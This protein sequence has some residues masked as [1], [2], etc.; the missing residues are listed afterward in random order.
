MVQTRSQARVAFKNNEE[1]LTIAKHF[2]WIEETSKI[3]DELKTYGDFTL[4]DLWDPGMYACYNYI[5]NSI[6]LNRSHTVWEDNI[7]AFRFAAYH[8]LYH[9]LTRYEMYL[10]TFF[11]SFLY[12]LACY[13]FG[14]VYAWGF[15][16]CMMPFRIL[17]FHNWE[18]RCDLFSIA[19]NKT[20]KGGIE[21]IKIFT[22]A[23]K[24]QEGFTKRSFL[25]KYFVT[26]EGRNLLD[27]LHPSPK[28]RIRYMT[29][30]CQKHNLSIA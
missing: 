7:D 22:T 1:Y 16:F 30:Y 18:K 12:L 28:E 27:I 10:I 8:E 3:K 4:F 6:L 11:D 21:F 5:F 15:S 20:A 14:F 17:W 19:H 13:H 2:T 29:E 24:S 26:K 23:T 9:Y 25:R